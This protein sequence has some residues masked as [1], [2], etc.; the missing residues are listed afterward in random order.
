[1]A[2]DTD[3]QPVLLFPSDWTLRYFVERNADVT[4]HEVPAKKAERES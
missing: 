3:G 1:M 2:E 4:L